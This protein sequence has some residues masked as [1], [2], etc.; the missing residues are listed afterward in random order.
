MAN[1]GEKSPSPFYK[2]L[3]FAQYIYLMTDSLNTLFQR[4]LDRL[5]KELSLYKNDTDVW[6]LAGDIK[7]SGGT[8]VLHLVGN[9]QHFIGAVFGSSGYIRDRKNEFN[10]RNISRDEL[11]TEIE[12]TKQVLAE[13][14]PN[15]SDEVLAS[16]SSDKVP[17]D[18]TNEQFLIHFY[19]HFGYHLG[20]LNYHRRLMAE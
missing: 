16:Q 14:L 4:D 18:I 2:R 15:I 20:Q 6:R 19:G 8:L 13:N 10:A 5:A 17:F 9:L 3:F 7:N 1:L 12:K 11:L